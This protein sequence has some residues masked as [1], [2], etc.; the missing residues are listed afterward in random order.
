MNADRWGALEVRHLVALLAVAEASSFSR[1]AD[2]LGYTQSAVSQQIGALERLVGTSLFERPGGPRRVR[3]TEA[4]ALLRDHAEVVLARVG[5]AEA[6]LRALAQGE[7]GTVRVGTIQ[8]IG[9]QVL[10]EVLRRFVLRWP[11]VQVVFHEAADC[12]DLLA[13]VEAGELDLAFVALPTPPGPFTVHEVLEDPAV[14]VCAADAPEATL[15]SVTVDAIGR[16][17]LVGNRNQ[18][19]QDWLTGYFDEL[20][21]QPTFVFRSDD[22]TII[23]RCIAAGLGRGL[24][25]WLTIDHTDPTVAVI[26]V[27]PP[28]APRRLALVSHQARRP[29][30]ATTAFVELA[31]AVCAELALKMP[32]PVLTMAER[33]SSRPA[34]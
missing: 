7:G 28:V 32:S 15:T 8:S 21:E 18:H 13:L 2:A 25:P 23:Q 5:A 33:R 29:G 16:L 1:A 31:E 12:R 34:A 24:L 20:P 17:P 30:R 4:G 19:C 10:P 22:N 3:L 9:T 14:F 6:D 11:E 27:D 26:P